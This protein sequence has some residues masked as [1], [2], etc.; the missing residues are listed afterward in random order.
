MLQ[1]RR[2]WRPILNILKEKFQPRISYPAKLIFTSK[3][4]TKSHA[5]K[6][7]LRDFVTTIPALQEVQKEALNIERK[8]HY[9]PL[10]KHTK[11]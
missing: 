7:T 6:Q 10:Q 8:N 3:E 2:Q 5:D 1:A 9:Q 11:F 4:E